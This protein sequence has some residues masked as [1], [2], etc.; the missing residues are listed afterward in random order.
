MIPSFLDLPPTPLP[1]NHPTHLGHHRATSWT[2]CTLH[3]FLLAICF[4][5]GSIYVSILTSQLMHIVWN[6]GKWYRGTYFQARS[7]D[8][9]IENGCV[10]L[11][12]FILV[13]DT[14]AE[15]ER[16]RKRDIYGEKW[17]TMWLGPIPDVILPQNSSI[18]GPL[19]GYFL[20]LCSG[21]SSL[22]FSQGIFA[23]PERCISIPMQPRLLEKSHLT[24]MTW[25]LISWASVV[26]KSMVPKVLAPPRFP[27]LCT[28]QQTL[29]Q[30][31]W[32]SFGTVIALRGRVLCRMQVSFN[33]NQE[34][35]PVC[36]F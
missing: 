1:P 23:V 16:Q 36:K 29:W 19:P 14:R 4:T 33:N 28:T 35:L 5:R 18:I 9:S 2:F 15:N 34:H 26:T 24:S 7:R 31:P 3:W 12:L 27:S 32:D 17:F 22:L 6:L 20:T 10:H 25:K 11:P 30:V 8:A 13:K 21:S